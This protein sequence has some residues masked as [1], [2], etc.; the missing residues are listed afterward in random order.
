MFTRGWNGT[1]ST[2]VIRKAVHRCRALDEQSSL[3]RCSLSLAGMLGKLTPRALT[4]SSCW[5]A[6]ITFENQLLLIAVRLR[7]SNMVKKV[8]CLSR[9]FGQ[10]EKSKRSSCLWCSVKES[11]VWE[12]VIKHTVWAAWA[13]L[14]ARRI[15]NTDSAYRFLKSIY[16]FTQHDFNNLFIG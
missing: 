8:R 14:D 6:R 1:M 3:T 4:S 2:P 16:K 12:F 7:R 9:S 5:I 11:R 13:R 15:Y 10:R